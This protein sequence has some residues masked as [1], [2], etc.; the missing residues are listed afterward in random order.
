[1]THA[2]IQCFN[3]NEMGHYASDCPAAEG[4]P[5]VQLF[6]DAYC[7]AQSPKYTG[8]PRLWILLDTQSTTLVFN[9][10]DM[11]SD[12]RPSDRTL[13]VQTNGGHQDSKMMGTFHNLWACLVQPS[14]NRQ[15]PVLG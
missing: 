3:C 12:I 8:L 13:R 1:M 5:N 10:P 4:G 7:L 9:N 14:I 15:H 6:Q 2:D 11:L